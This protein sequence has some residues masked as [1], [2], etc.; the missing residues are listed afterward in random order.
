MEPS[1]RKNVKRSRQK[2]E[3]K[4]NQGGRKEKQKVSKDKK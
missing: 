3:G 4:T 1:E 2:C